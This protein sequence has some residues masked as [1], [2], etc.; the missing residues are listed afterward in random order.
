MNKHGLTPEQDSAV[1]YEGGQLLVSA[2]AGS[3][4]TKVLV[5]HLLRHVAGGESNIDEFLVITYTRTAAAEL[6]EKILD[7]L[8]ERTAQDPGNRHL[9]KQMLR[10]YSAPI[11]TIHSFCA[12]ILRQNAHLTALTPDFRVAE[13]SETAM[14]KT[15]VLDDVLDRT[16]A[17][18]G[19]KFKMLVDTLSPG[20]DDSRLIRMI[21]DT[22]AKLQSSPSPRQWIDA[23]IQLLSMPGVSDVSE[24]IWG[25]HLLD[26]ARA[27]AEFWLMEMTDVR[28]E[29]RSLPEFD[30]AYGA[31]FEV[32]IA[33]IETFL[34]AIDTGW[35]A[36]RLAAS[37]EFPRVRPISGYEEFKDIRNKC[38]DELKKCST[39]LGNSS[40][41]L[42]E[43]MRAIAPAMTVFL[44]LVENFDNAYS[45][46]KRRRGL[47]DFS[48]LEHLT[49]NL[50]RDE[51]TGEP[52]KLAR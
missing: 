30:N 32:T 33:G 25:R 35:D 20:R 13:E 24:T 29:I 18:G 43:D 42:I 1:Q 37:V 41:E 2:A 38:K 16:Y 5:E 4:K 6:R 23:Q 26:R 39:I 45:E 3:G 34:D 31:S 12:D 51:E 40:H 52:T 21:Q 28:A 15:E 49:L 27:T 22:H 7:E 10:C 14:I 50:L 17:S 8:S 36:A 44:R 47:V 11:G 19:E 48:D 46:E 9:R